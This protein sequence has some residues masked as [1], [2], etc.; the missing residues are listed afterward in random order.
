MTVTSSPVLGYLF[1]D[2]PSFSFSIIIRNT[3][4]HNA[5]RTD[6]WVIPS[7]NPRHNFHTANYPNIISLAVKS[8]TPS[9]WTYVFLVPVSVCFHP[10]RSP[11][12]LY[13]EESLH[14]RSACPPHISI[15]LQSLP[16]VIGMRLLHIVAVYRALVWLWFCFLPNESRTPPGTAS[17]RLL[18][19]NND[20]KKLLVSRF[21]QFHPRSPR[22]LLRPFWPHTASWAWCPAAEAYMQSPDIHTPPKWGRE[23]VWIRI[24]CSDDNHH[25]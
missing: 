22:L 11:L 6:N 20:S 23:K 21:H 1:P 7:R 3:F 25:W 5:T 15:R 14:Q 24:L 16:P 12:P 4:C 19:R 8:F 9:H 10:A 2:S 18:H 13:L 17:R